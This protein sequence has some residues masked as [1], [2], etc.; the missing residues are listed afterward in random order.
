M[1]ANQ[2]P[3]TTRMRYRRD[4]TLDDNAAFDSSSSIIRNY[5]GF[6]TFREKHC[7]N[8]P[9]QCIFSFTLTTKRATRQSTVL[10]HRL[11]VLV[12]IA[13][14]KLSAHPPLLCY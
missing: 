11:V 5:V 6:P 13:T 12:L 8:I 10:F 9:E 1:T 2:Y 4:G 3:W 7:E 14:S